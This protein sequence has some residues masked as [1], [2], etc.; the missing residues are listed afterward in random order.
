M[1]FKHSYWLGVF[2]LYAFLLMACKTKQPLRPTESYQDMYSRPLSNINI[3][4]SIDLN[5]VERIIN[6]QIPTLL[7]DD[8]SYSDN[9]GDKLMIRAE[10]SEDIHLRIE[11]QEVFYAVPLNIW[12]RKRIA[13]LTDV[14]AAGELIIDLKTAFEV[15]G[16]WSVQSQ[17]TLER[18]QWLKKPVVKLGLV[19]LPVRLIANQVIERSQ[20]TL[21]KAI[22]DQIQ[23]KLQLKEQIQ[24]VWEQV[25]EPLL[26]SKEYN[27]WVTI[28]PQ[29]IAMTPLHGAGD[30]VKSTISIA[31]RSEVLIGERPS[32]QP[33]SIL[34]P[35]RMLE[36]AQEQFTLQVQTHIPYKEA[37]KI[38]KQY[39]LGETFEHA[40]QKI[41][42]EDI[43]LYGQ[44]NHLVVNT[45][46][47]GAYNGH[48]Y[49]TG[50]PVYDTQKEVI[51]LEKLDYELDTKN[52]L[53][54]SISWLFKKG[55]KKRI[56]EGIRFPLGEKMAEIREMSEEKLQA[57]ELTP[58]IKLDGQLEELKVEGTSLSPSGIQAEVRIS[59]Q[60][61]LM[62][63]GLEQDLFPIAK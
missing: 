61:N 52:F 60:V 19:R 31:A 28:R 45:R 20:H 49:L 29:Q 41:R 40:N 27:M 43:N 38:A 2:L 37:E 9:N 54:K 58:D 25:R 36:S 24:K 6:R 18:Y 33:D 42:I 16:D 35:F 46:V 57:F 4:I 32:T 63:K 47:S 13:G 53:L 1:E 26:L 30:F 14:E 23:N 5:E 50:I 39:L 44:N 59:G 11:H 10:K 55:M 21:T 3:P 48:I 22:D 62:V 34:P 12:V 17:T 56:S 8:D 15:Q 51:T 7:Y